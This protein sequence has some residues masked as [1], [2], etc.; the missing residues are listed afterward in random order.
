MLVAW[1]LLMETYASPSVPQ[2]VICRKAK[3]YTPIT[4]L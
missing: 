2:E 3:H 1:F 4:Y